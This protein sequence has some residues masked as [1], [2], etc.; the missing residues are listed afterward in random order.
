ML[1]ITVLKYL[2]MY[3]ESKHTNLTELHKNKL[4]IAILLIES[5]INDLDKQGYYK[6]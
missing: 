2:K 3:N 6:E 4:S 1:L 5:V